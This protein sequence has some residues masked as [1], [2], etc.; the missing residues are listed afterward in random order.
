MLSKFFDIVYT[1]TGG[2]PNFS[3][4]TLVTYIY[5]RAFEVNRMGY[6]SALSVCLFILILIITIILYTRMLIQEKNN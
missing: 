2:G 5:T 6:A 3:T 1:T 4:E